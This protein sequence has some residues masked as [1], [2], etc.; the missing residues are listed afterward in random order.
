MR[1]ANGS[2]A[3]YRLLCLAFSPAAGVDV[4][5]AVFRK[6]AQRAFSPAEQMAATLLH[7]VL[8]GYVRLW[9]LHREERRRANAFKAALDVSDVGVVV[10]NR[11]CEVIFESRRARDIL[12]RST[13]LR[14]EGKFV[15]PETPADAI[16]LQTAFQQALH[17]NLAPKTLPSERH[18]APLLTLKRSDGKRPLIAAVFGLPSP[19]R[20]SRDAAVLCYVIDPNKDF[21]NLIAPLCKIYKLSH[22]EARLTCLLTSGHTLASAAGQMHVQEATARSY[23]KTVFIKT[24]TNRQTDLV[25]LMLSSLQHVNPAIELTPV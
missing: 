17:F 7:P 13:G 2:D 8:E 9:W 1:S 25:R 3:S 16:K 14:R 12:D 10:L 20:D 19:A 18:F 24:A 21:L 6:D 4:I 15:S 22:A 5:A 23:L 11:R